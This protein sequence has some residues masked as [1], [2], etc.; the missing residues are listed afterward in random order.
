MDQLNTLKESLNEDEDRYTYVVREKTKVSDLY[1]VEAFKLFIARNSKRDVIVNQNWS[2]YINVTVKKIKDQFLVSVAL[3]NDSKVQSNEK[4][5]Q[6]NKR[7]KDKP[8]IETLFNSGVDISLS[9]AE[10]TPIEL[11]YFLDD[12]KYD[13]EQRAVGLNCS[14]TYSAKGNIISTDHLPTFIQKRLVTND[15]LAVKFQDLIDQPLSTLKNIRKKMDVEIQEWRDYYTAKAPGLTEN[16]KKKCKRR[17]SISS[18]RLIVSNWALIRLRTIL[19]SLKV[20]C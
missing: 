6:S 8:S 12:Y 17:Y 13:K 4:T 9:N 1:S 10:Y 11:D 15:K 20:S 3:V 16:G 2:I 18:W 7:D 19:S 14:V 5:H